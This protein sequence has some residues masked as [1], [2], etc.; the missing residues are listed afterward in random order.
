MTAQAKKKGNAG[1]KSLTI[2]EEEVMG[3][4]VHIGKCFGKRTKEQYEERKRYWLSTVDERT[5]RKAGDRIIC[6]Y[7][8]SLISVD[9]PEF[10]FYI[11]AYCDCREKKV[12]EDERQALARKRVSE[13]RA[14]NTMLIP[15][16]LQG[17]DFIKCLTERYTPRYLETCQVLERYCKS[18]HNALE[19]GRGVWLHGG[20]DTGKTYLAVCMLKTLQEQGYTC[21]FTSQYRIAEEFRD[22]YNAK[23]EITERELMT[24]Y[25]YVDC[26]IIDY[27]TKIKA[28]RKK[29]DVWFMDKL[30]EL[31]KRRTDK[32]KPSII[33]SRNSLRELYVDDGLPAPIVEKLKRTMYAVELTDNKRI[34]VQQRI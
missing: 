12:K 24:K 30:N 32:H 34:P 25:A 22:T 1:K 31:I 4:L 13:Y 19:D 3:D 8:G 26:L 7:C 15:V 29:E 6:G 33:T 28:G 5:E 10:N 11:K 23:S 20:C 16:E 21:L 27:F 2:Y 9:M 14:E 18:Y 17:A